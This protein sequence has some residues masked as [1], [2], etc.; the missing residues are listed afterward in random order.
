MCTVKSPI[1][2]NIQH[3]LNVVWESAWRDSREDSILKQKSISLETLPGLLRDFELHRSLSQVSFE[4]PRFFTKLQCQPTFQR[5]AGPCVRVEFEGRILRMA[6]AAN[7]SGTQMSRARRRFLSRQSV[8]VRGVP[9]DREAL[10]TKV[11]LGPA[12]SLSRDSAQKY[13]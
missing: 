12:K 10:S 5:S 4:S 3:S 11:R 2:P 13:G 9:V 1:T 6:F 8:I 7:Q